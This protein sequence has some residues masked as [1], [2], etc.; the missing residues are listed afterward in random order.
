ML[1]INW[2][3]LSH[4]QQELALHAAHAYA[5]C[6]NAHRLERTR[7]VLRQVIEGIGQQVLESRALDPAMYSQWSHLE[8]RAVTEAMAL[9]LSKKLPWIQ[10]LPKNEA[11]YPSYVQEGI[12]YFRANLGKYYDDD[13]AIS[14]SYLRRRIHKCDIY[15]NTRVDEIFRQF[16]ENGYGKLVAQLKHERVVWRRK[17]LLDL[18][19]P[20]PDAPASVME[21]QSAPTESA[22]EATVADMLAD[23]PEDAADLFEAGCDRHNFGFDTQFQTAD[24]HAGHNFTFTVTETVRVPSAE[25]AQAVVTA[26]ETKPTQ[27][28]LEHALVQLEDLRGDVT[29]EFA[30]LH[31]RVVSSLIYAVPMSDKRRASLILSMAR[32]ED[33]E[34]KDSDC[35]AQPQYLPESFMWALRESADY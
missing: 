34:L 33:I 26:A 6:D 20:F 1:L 17:N 7:M 25:P 4:A 19:E 10:G 13:V 8:E 23:F 30:A 24:K 28:W 3:E 15:V 14:G 22:A 9:H 32:P 11:D 12:A 21:K 18:Q 29:S 16:E 35:F 2:H 5:Y 27:G 31:E